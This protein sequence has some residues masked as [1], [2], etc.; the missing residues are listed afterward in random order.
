MANADTADASAGARFHRCAL[1]VNSAHY[2]AA[3]GGDAADP[4]EHAEAIVAKASELGVTVLAITDHHNVSGVLDFQRA[5][6]P[7]GI[8]VFPGFELASSEGVHILC[9]YPLD[10]DLQALERYLGEFGIRAPDNFKGT[11][12]KTFTAALETVRQQGGVAIAAHATAPSGGLLKVLSGQAR[13]SAWRHAGLLAIQIPGPVN[14]LPA[15]LLPIVRNRNPEYRRSAAGNDLA[16]AV[17]NTSDVSDPA[18]LENPGATCLIKMSDVSIDG[19]RQ[20]FLDP[21]SRIRLV[22]DDEPPPHAELVSLSWD[23]GFLDGAEIRFSPN[24]NVLVGG[25][26]AGKSTVVESL[27]YVLGLDP[28]GDDARSTHEGMV[29]QVLRAGTTI[30]LRVRS[31][32]PTPREYLIE[33]T[34]PNPPRVTDGDGRLTELLPRDIIPRAEVYGQHEIA[35]LA[36]SPGT[37]TEMLHRFAEHDES[38]DRRKAD[39]GRELAKTRESLLDIHRESEEN[40]ARLSRLPGLEETLARYREAGLEE[41]LGNRGALVREERVL[42]SLSER[43]GVF[44][45]WTRNLQHDLPIDRAFVSDRALG[46]LPGRDLLT[47]AN[48]ILERLSAELERARASMD[49]AISRAEGQVDELRGRWDEHRQE[50]EAAYRDILRRLQEGATDGEHFIQLQ[51]ETEALRPLR[52]RK[53]LLARAE[54]EHRERRTKLL[55]DWES[56]MEEEFRSLDEA[57]SAVTRKLRGRVRVRVTARGD[58]KPLIDL[59]REEISGRLAEAIEVFRDAPGLKPAELAGRCLKG[60]DSL[61]EAWPAI[62]MRQAESLAAAAPDALMR[63]EESELRAATSVELN[64]AA[65]DAQPN[66]QPLDRLSTGQRATAVLLLLLLESDAPLI[67]DQPE[68]DLDNRFITEGIVP[69]MRAEKGRRQFVFS[70]HNAN[71]PVLGDAELI[72]GLTPSGEA[73]RGHAVI[74]PEHI[75]AIDTPSV[76]SLVEEVLEGGRDAFERRRLKYGF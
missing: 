51:R 30:S 15:N 46:E 58:R 74:R 72:L 16:V 42:D 35:E 36:R 68:D 44:R 69:R 14:N 57:A 5:A 6:A 65:D 8:H 34:V 2:V 52:Q 29:H 7:R 48:A 26:G 55:A 18:G 23:G 13:M 50:I 25:R 38:L 24:L 73:D 64:T 20:A 10:E 43:V 60:A 66:W 32:L 41:R 63:I 45:D 33:R 3:T 49:D 76:R 53:E 22:S 1:Q 4:A 37:L 71:I 39:L 40:E 70:T 21:D 9:I 61:R 67:I 75:G 27:R 56:L 54:Q 19:L 59:L 62:P 17:V 11:S 47:D 12:N 31:A 28:L